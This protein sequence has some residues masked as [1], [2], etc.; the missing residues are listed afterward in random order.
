MYIDNN[1]NDNNNNNNSSNNNNN[2]DNNDNDSN[3]SNNNNNDNNNWIAPA[4]SRVA[5]IQ[6]KLRGSQ[7]VGGRKQRPVRLCFALDS[8][9]VQILMLTDVQTPFLGTPLLPLKV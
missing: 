3:N 5:R 8:L 6:G 4:A 2:N 9:H 1:N 7:G